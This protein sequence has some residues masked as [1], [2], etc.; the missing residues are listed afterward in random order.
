MGY[1]DNYIMSRSQLCDLGKMTPYEFYCRYIKKS[2]KS[3]DKQCYKFGRAFH[4]YILEDK[5]VFNKMFIVLPDIDRRTKQGK[6][7]YQEFCEKSKGKDILSIKEYNL[8]IDICM[9]LDKNIASKLLDNC[10]LKEEEFYFEL[11]GLDFKAKLDAVDTQRHI[12]YDLKTVAMAYMV[13][14][15]STSVRLGYDMIKYSNAEQIYIYSEAYKLR[16]G[17]IPTFYFICCEKK[18]PHETQVFDGTNLYEFGK[19]N[20]HDLISKYKSL[21]EKF[22]SDEWIDNDINHIGLPVS[23]E[24]YLLEDVEID[25]L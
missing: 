4:C 20:T 12:I 16:Y 23:A 7:D 17:V 8:I 2:L 24:R 10:D 21:V 6:I 25:Y 5:E 19:K 13:D 3:S 18:E 15:N 1:Y 22:G 9:S 14:D 11:G